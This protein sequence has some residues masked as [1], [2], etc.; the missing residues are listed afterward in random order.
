MHIITLPKQSIYTLHTLSKTVAKIT[1][2]R[3]KLSKYKEM[4]YLLKLSSLVKHQRIRMLFSQF[5]TQLNIEQ[6]R[7]LLQSGIRLP[8]KIVQKVQQPF[9][10]STAKIAYYKVKTAFDSIQKKLTDSLLLAS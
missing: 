6:L 10:L 1:G 9:W 7:G 2:Y 5:I 8:V 4:I 3:C